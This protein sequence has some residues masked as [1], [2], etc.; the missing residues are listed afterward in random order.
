M[1][2]SNVSLNGEILSNLVSSRRLSRRR[3]LINPSLAPPY[4]RLEDRYRRPP[5]RRAA[6]YTARGTARRELS[7]EHQPEH[8]RFEGMRESA[9]GGSGK[10]TTKMQGK[11]PGAR[12]LRD[13]LVSTVRFSEAVQLFFGFAWFCISAHHGADMLCVLLG[14][15]RV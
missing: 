5:S 4:A 6:E 11:N 14:L 3:F 13:L 1:N 7:T 8:D 12:I 2:Q 9:G 10:K 15:I